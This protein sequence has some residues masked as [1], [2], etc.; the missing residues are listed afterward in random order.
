MIAPPHQ[1]ASVARSIAYCAVLAVA[2][3]SAVHGHEL[4]S[5]GMFDFD[6]WGV[7]SDL[8]LSG[9][10][11]V[12]SHDLPGPPTPVPVV[13][14]GNWTLPALTNWAL[15]H[16]PQTEQAWATLRAS[17]DALGIAKGLWL[18]TASLQIQGQYSNTNLTG[19]ILPI[20]TES[21][22]TNLTLSEIL[23]DF[24]QRQATIAQS[25]AAEWVAQYQAGAAIQQIVQSVAQSYYTL[26]YAQADV[27]ELGETVAD[28]EFLVDTTRRL[29]QAH[30]R[31]ITDMYQAQT[32]L[33]R[34]KQQWI[35]AQG[36][37]Q[38]AI[39]TLA[40]VVG[41]H[42][43]NPLRIAPLQNPPAN[44]PNDIKGLLTRALQ[45]NPSVLA[46]AASV[47]QA[48]ASLNL[49]KAQGR[50]ILTIVTSVGNNIYRDQPNSNNYAVSLQI[51]IPFDAN[52]SRRYQ[53]DQQ[54]NLLQQAKAQER[55]L[56]S[57]VE[58]QVWQT[59]H[60]MQSAWR[61]YRTDLDQVKSAGLS[62]AG[63]RTQYR[64]GLASVLDVITAEQNLTSARLSQA[65]DLASTYQYLAVLY[66]Y[67]GVPPN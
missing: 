6:P 16:N 4:P 30:L 17:A 66:A 8:P 41:M 39:G 11:V 9:T 37:Q 59:F 55:V 34:V 18:P 5:S 32:Q 46:S 48:E 38:S 12:P 33:A 50:P 3:P 61:A 40:Q 56:A 2:T 1:F 54:Y 27:A 44:V 52:F 21:I 22:Y 19:N 45:T 25:E 29:Y 53:V 47:K 31:P 49:A 7:R 67:V 35:L 43:D 65:K 60:L 63:I 42:V 10:Y 62:L 64:M 36:T 13:G 24:G 28:A 51:S 20:G 58:L 57:S 23:Y 15:E 26:A 14:H